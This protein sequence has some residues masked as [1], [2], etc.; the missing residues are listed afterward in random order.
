MAGVSGPI[1]DVFFARSEMSRQA[2]VATKAMSQCVSHLLK[3][4]Y[5]GGLVAGIGSVSAWT[6]ARWSC[7]LSWGRS[8]RVPCSSASARSAFRRW[9]RWT[10]MATA[11]C[12]LASGC[13]M[14]A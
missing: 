3:I 8:C 12:Y 11:A 10:V 5:F 7:S 4:V 13:M 14:L 2:V 9:T 6:A 1:L